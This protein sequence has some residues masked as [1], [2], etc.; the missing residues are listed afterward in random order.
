[1]EIMLTV[2]GVCPYCDS[3]PTWQYF[4][5]DL[6]RWIG[7]C[8]PCGWMG[9]GRAITEAGDVGIV[10]IALI[11]EVG[12]PNDVPVPNPWAGIYRLATDTSPWVTWEPAGAPCRECDTHAVV[13][14]LRENPGQRYEFELCLECGEVVVSRI[15]KANPGLVRL[16]VGNVGTAPTSMGVQW[17]VRGLSL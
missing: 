8:D 5:C 1:M 15:L 17:L 10:P 9:R 12:G 14:G 2:Q 11:C 3:R 16:D 4:E 6:S 13:T 7:F